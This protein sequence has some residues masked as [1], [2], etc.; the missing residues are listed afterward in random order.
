V[1]LIVPTAVNVAPVKIFNDIKYKVVGT[2]I[3]TTPHAVNAGILNK[4]AGIVLT[5]G[6]PLE[7]RSPAITL[8]IFAE[9]VDIETF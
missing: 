7:T 5:Y 8:F 6:I 9:T 1:Y 4:F 2:V 3:L